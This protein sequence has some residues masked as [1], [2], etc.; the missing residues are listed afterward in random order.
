MTIVADYLWNQ[1]QLLQKMVED[2]DNLKTTLDN[3]QLE[4]EEEE[5]LP[6]PKKEPEVLTAE[7][8]HA[9]NLFL[10]AQKLLNRTKPDKKAAYELLQE[11]A[12]LENDEA[13]SLLAWSE[14]LGVPPII[15]PNI[16]ASKTMFETLAEKGV[17]AGHAGLGFM[18]AIGLGV[19]VSQSRALVHYVFGA[20]GGD[21]WAHMALGYR[22]WAG[23]TVAPS[24]EKALEHYRK[25]AD[26]GKVINKLYKY[27][28]VDSSMNIHQHIFS[29]PR[30]FLQ[31][32][33]S[34]S[35]DQITGRTRKRLHLRNFGQRLDRIL[36]IVG[37][38]R[39]RSGTSKSI[40][41]WSR[42]IGKIKFIRTVLGGFGAVALSRRK[43]SR[44]GLSESLALLHASCGSRKCRCNGLFGKGNFPS[45]HHSFPHFTFALCLALFVDLL[46][47]KRRS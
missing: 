17:G 19:N 16:N 15:K 3:Q 21:T 11:A 47:G 14:L 38:K 43:R 7:Q 26:K 29:E 13:L 5:I 31:W 36:S 8:K 24:C 39:R 34:N 44:P 27:G 35:K 42:S 37:R 45:F 9:H 4:E 2:F 10:E 20:L 32:W 33:F 22:Y 40:S 41:M 1:A 18:H 6:P 30:S 23:V 46:G 25:V 12:K 28:G